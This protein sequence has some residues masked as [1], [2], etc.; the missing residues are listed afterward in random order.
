MKEKYVITFYSGEIL[1]TATVESNYG[2]YVFRRNL[3]E[4][5]FEVIPGCW[6]MPAAIMKVEVSQVIREEHV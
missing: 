1:H 4:Y 2:S 6:I 3:I 5:G